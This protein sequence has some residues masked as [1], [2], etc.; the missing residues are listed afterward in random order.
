MGETAPAVMIDGDAEV[1]GN[2]IAYPD[3]ASLSDKVEARAQL[4]KLGIKVR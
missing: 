1:N 4:R 3:G 2:L